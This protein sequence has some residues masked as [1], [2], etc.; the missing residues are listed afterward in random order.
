MNTPAS[1][2]RALSAGQAGDEA[3]GLIQKPTVDG[4][5]RGAA[6]VSA[7]PG[8]LM[9][10]QEIADHLRVGRATIHRLLKRNQIPAFRIGRH[11]RFN[12]E[13][14]DKWCECHELSR[15]PE[16]DV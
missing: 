9:T 14:I 13:E 7:L 15:Q 6:A 11:W 16:P 2:I 1:A 8:T 4:K 12:V 5:K 10:L 3:A